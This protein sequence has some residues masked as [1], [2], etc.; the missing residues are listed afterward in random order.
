MAKRIIAAVLGLLAMAAALW[1]AL[2]MWFIPT[3]PG[4]S[5][6][7]FDLIFVFVGGL[8]SVAIGLLALR[9]L[10]FGVTGRPLAIGLIGRLLL[11]L[12]CF[13]PGFVFSLIPSVI[14]AARLRSGNGDRAI[15]VAFSVSAGIGVL[16]SALGVVHFVKKHRAGTRNPQPP[17]NSLS[18][19]ETNLTS[20]S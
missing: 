11:G 6:E 17:A 20:Q 5:K 3:E 9:F 12:G 4:G 19:P 7:P 1:L 10:H 13:F 18:G 16:C 2:D 8:I 14:L 15:N